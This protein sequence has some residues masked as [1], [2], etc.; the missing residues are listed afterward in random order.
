MDEFV[1]AGT[2]SGA[3]PPN[4]ALLALETERS[5]TELGFGVTF[6]S[7]ESPSGRRME[8]RFNFARPIAGK[9]NTPRGARID[10]GLRLFK[11]LWGG[12][13]DIEDIE[14]PEAVKIPADTLGGASG[15]P[16]RRAR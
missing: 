2:P 7:L 8:A 15:G 4:P 11:R 14:Y 3:T 10:V 9:G 5:L 16:A 1:L 6:S 13:P 12:P